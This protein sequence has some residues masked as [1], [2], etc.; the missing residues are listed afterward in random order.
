MFAKS[1]SKGG[2]SSRKVTPPSPTYMSNEQFAAYLADLRNN[3]TKRPSGARPLPGSIRDPGRHSMSGRSS[4]VNQPV[5]ETASLHQRTQSDIPTYSGRPSISASISSRYSSMTQGKDYIPKEP[6]KPLKPS[7]VV[8]TATYIERGQR[9]MEKE[10]AF[11]LRQAMEDMELREEAQGAQQLENDDEERRIY[12][13]ALNEAAELVWRH[14]HPASV[15]EPS[16]PYR[17]KPHLRKNS[18]A[19]AR[20]ASAGLYG[21]D[22]AP[23]GLSRDAPSRSVSGSSTDSDALGS[24][25][26]RTSFVS[27]RKP[28]GAYSTRRES[29]DKQRQ[30]PIEM[31]PAKPYSGTS[32]AP[33]AT[34][35]GRRRSSLKRNISGEVE[36]PFSGIHIWEEPEVQTPKKEYSAPE[37]SSQSEETSNEVRPL[38][39]KPKNPLNRVQFAPGSASDVDPPS[40][41]P[42]KLL[43]KVEIYRNIPTQSR[44]P[45]YTTNSRSVSPIDSV[46]SVP[47]KQGMEIRSDDIR[48]ATSMR[49]RDRSPKLPTP[50]A[51]SDNPG[52]PIVSFD[53]NWKPPEEATD[54]KP[55][56][57]KF[58]RGGPPSP[59]VSSRDHEEQQQQTQ[60]G[61]VIAISEAPSSSSPPPPNSKPVPAAPTIQVDGPPIPTIAVS[62]SYPIPTIVLQDEPES[63]PDLP[64]LITPDDQSSPP[65]AQRPLPTPNSGASRS[66]FVRRRGHWSPAPAPVSTRATARCHE[67][68]QPIEGRFVSLAGIT[69]RFHPQCFICYTCGTSLEALEISPEPEDHRAAR[70]ERIARRAAGEQL[71]EVPGQTMAEDGDDRLRFYCHLDWHEQFA[72]RC[73]HCKTPI[74]GEHVVALGAHWHYGHFFCAEC[75]DPFERGATHIE[76]DGYAWCVSCQT[77][78]TERRAPKC[79]KCKTAVIGQY[80]QAL[81]GEW[82]DECFRCA[83]CGGGF[84]DG[85]IFPMEGRDAT[86]GQT[87]V[88]CTACRQRELK[89]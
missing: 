25:R 50:S 5:S 16:A 86:P 67:C 45:Q 83:T 61:P 10:E 37:S 57:S 27:S 11:F 34:R 38:S 23:T 79:R 32:G 88:L 7:E 8:P 74:L 15:P 56:A 54:E 77:K 39:V 80:V 41:P 59:R 18:Y 13:A 87:V 26:S 49:L 84:D 85:Q 1:K 20:T 4:L 35:G 12:N 72:P 81:G 63:N 64:I 58:G 52:R 65:A 22:V 2:T 62:D 71:P 21:E 40:P 82:H 3:R 89:A 46:E 28:S 76:K 9:W 75:G 53:K 43:D 55:E 48:Q 68:S 19:H 78:R 44:N 60:S 42:P 66:P 30:A 51:V 47:R 70:L 36:K 33:F 73:K 69:E 17:Y 29:L 6:V 31:K 24:M 14:Q